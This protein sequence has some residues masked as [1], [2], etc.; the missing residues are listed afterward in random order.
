MLIVTHLPQVSPRF[1]LLNV[2]SSDFKSRNDSRT[3]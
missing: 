2:H 1:T 3:I